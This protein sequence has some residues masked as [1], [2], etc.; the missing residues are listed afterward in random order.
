MVTC[1]DCGLTITYNNLKYTHKRYCKALKEKQ[2]ESASASTP[3]PAPP[4]P[5][6]LLQRGKRHRLLMSMM[7]TAD[8]DDVNC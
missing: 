3:Q 5:P 6:G 8:V 4:P 2:E 1:P 7:L